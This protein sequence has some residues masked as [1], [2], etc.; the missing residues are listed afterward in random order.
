MEN[1][2][3]SIADGLRE[4]ADWYEKHPEVGLP[5]VRIELDSLNADEAIRGLALTAK[6]FGTCEKKFGSYLISINRRFG[7]VRVSAHVDR[8]S[9]CKRVVTWKCPE[10]LLATL[11]RDA[12]KALEEA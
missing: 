4:L 1:E 7:P 3:K 5:S 6:A 8:D 11:G 10:S 12:V 2:E 9:V